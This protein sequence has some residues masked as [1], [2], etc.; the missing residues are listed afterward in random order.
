[1]ALIPA[2]KATLAGTT[3]TYTAASTSDTVKLRKNATYHVKNGSGGS[4]TFTMVVPGNDD[5]AQAKGDVAASVG[6]GAEKVFVFNDSMVDEATGLITLT[7]SAATS[8]TVA[9]IVA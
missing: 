8:V 1:M 4:V 2:T 3:L 6:A 7:L 9:Y 5:N